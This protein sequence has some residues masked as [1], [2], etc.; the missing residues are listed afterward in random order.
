M[1][2]IV[3]SELLSLDGVAEDPNTFLSDWDDDEMDANM[4]A[5]IDTQDAAS[6]VGAPTTSGRRS[7]PGAPSSRSRRSSTGSRNTW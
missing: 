3:V 1:R 4:A 6:S 5:V 2:N 7:G